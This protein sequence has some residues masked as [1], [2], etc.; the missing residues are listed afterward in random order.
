MLYYSFRDLYL[1]G[2]LARGSWYTDDV[3]RPIKRLQNELI[4]AFGSANIP[5]TISLP[6]D[7][8]CI[9]TATKNVVGRYINTYPSTSYDVCRRS[10]SPDTTKGAFIHAEQNA[11]A[12]SDEAREAWVCALNNTFVSVNV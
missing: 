3:D 1:F 9:L 6:S 7:S 11:L 4:L 2:L 8:R 5:V 12:R 10:A